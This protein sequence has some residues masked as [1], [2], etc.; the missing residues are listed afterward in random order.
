MKPAASNLRLALVML[1]WLAQALLP[2]AHALAMAQ[3]EGGG[4]AW[5]GQSSSALAALSVM[6]PEIR[7]ALDDGAVSADHLNTCALLCAAGTGAPPVD[8]VAPTVAL[9]AAGLEP[10]PAPLSRPLARPQAPLPPAQAP[11]APV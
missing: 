11:P 3:A 2:V 4:R 9:R 8:D 10:T 1:A 6:P 5:C 7:Y